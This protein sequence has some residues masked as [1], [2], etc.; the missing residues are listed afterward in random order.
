LELAPV[1]ADAARIDYISSALAGIV[2]SVAAPV[3]SALGA[4]G[5]GE[6]DEA[7]TRVDDES[8]PLGDGRADVDVDVMGALVGVERDGQDGGRWLL[9]RRSCFVVPEA[10]AGEVAVAAPDVNHVYAAWRCAAAFFP[11]RPVE[12]RQR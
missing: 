4:R 10:A 3:R 8:L 1:P 9:R 2:V 6:G 11:G 12:L 5:A 7:G